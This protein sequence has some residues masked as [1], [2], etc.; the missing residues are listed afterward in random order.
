MLYV[1]YHGKLEAAI[2]IIRTGNE[3]GDADDGENGDAPASFKAKD[4]N[5]SLPTQQL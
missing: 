2:G 1:N 4:D 3:A 5:P